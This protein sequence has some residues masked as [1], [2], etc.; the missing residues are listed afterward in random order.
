MFPAASTDLNEKKDVGVTC[1]LLIPGICNSPKVISLPKVFT[2]LRVLFESSNV[3]VISK[4]APLIAE[5]T[6]VR[7]SPVMSKEKSED[8]D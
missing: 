2:N 6:S 3:A 7:S 8:C 4:F 1:A 5:A